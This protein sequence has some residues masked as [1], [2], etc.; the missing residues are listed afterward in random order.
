MSE[1][2]VCRIKTEP[3][4]NADRLQIGKLHINGVTGIQVIVG[5]DVANGDKVVFI[6]DDTQV[7][8]DFAHFNNLYTDPQLNY[9]NLIQGYIDPGNRRVRRIK[10]R[11]EPTEGLCL[12]LSCLWYI[13]PKYAHLSEGTDVSTLHGNMICQKYRTPE[14]IKMM[15]ERRSG[16]AKRNIQNFAEHYDTDK[17]RKAIINNRIKQ[18]DRFIVTEKLH[19]TSGRTGVVLVEEEIPVKELS[20]LTRFKNYYSGKK[21]TRR[22]W[23]KVSGTRRTV[24][25]LKNPVDEYR[26]FAHNSIEPTKGEVI[27]YELVGQDAFRNKPIMPRHYPQEEKDIL[28]YGKA[29]NYTYGTD[30]YMQ[31]YIY[32]ITRTNEDG[33]TIEL[34]W[35]QIQQRALELNQSVVPTLAKDLVYDGDSEA[36]LKLCEQLASGTSALD[37]S[38]PK[39][40]ICIRNDDIKGSPVYK[41]KSWLF[42]ELEGIAKNT[43]KYY[44]PEEA[45]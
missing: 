11:G 30:N 3:H 24:L 44:D 1:A 42:C 21:S 13:Y 27:Y 45:S 23:K 18:G 16:S 39:E 22:V 20:W 35:N 6:P 28:K 38:H 9:D 8:E 36:F 14:T 7:S 4:P 29:I 5:M 25:D 34:S 15:R 31:I 43:E 19:G 17:V 2:I 26:L 10:L 32:R 37:D 12:P 40:G 33:H 41:F